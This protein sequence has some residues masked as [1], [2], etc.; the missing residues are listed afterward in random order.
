M[1][2]NVY[3]KL[4]EI[5]EATDKIRGMVAEDLGKPE[6]SCS[7]INE[8]PDLVQEAINNNLQYYVAWIFTANPDVDPPAIDDLWI[9]TSDGT[10]INLP[11]G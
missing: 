6:V 7:T 10:V 1:S 9:D 2:Q 4:G 3:D 8:L 11:E 5:K